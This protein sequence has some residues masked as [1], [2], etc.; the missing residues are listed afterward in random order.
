MPTLKHI[1]IEITKRCNLSCV[2]CSAQS[3]TKGRE[4]NFTE[5][6]KILDKAVSLG[7]ENV[8]FT[9]GEPLIRKDKV[10]RLLHYS[11]NILDLKTHIHTNGTLLT[12]KDAS[13][14]AEL[15]DEISI[16]ILGAEARTHDKITSVKGSLEATE[17]G[18]KAILHE[19][20]NVRTYLVPMKSN[21]KET[22]QIIEKVS[23]AVKNSPFSAG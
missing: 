9:G 7:L 8:G 13:S 16:T 1:D 6:K 17:K 22:T 12:M 19:H 10:M 20:G 3:N 15:A 4:I 5:I 2:H 21:Y 23:M 11:K 14:L 18:L